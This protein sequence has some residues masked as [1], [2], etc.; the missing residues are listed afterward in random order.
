MPEFERGVRGVV[1]GP[2]PRLQARGPAA[3][4]EKWDTSTSYTSHFSHRATE[5]TLVV[6]PQ[7]RLVM[8]HSLRMS[9]STAVLFGILLLLS[10]ASGTE[11]VVE[12]TGLDLV[13]SWMPTL[14]RVVRFLAC[15]AG[16]RIGWFVADSWPLTPHTS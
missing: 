16:E 8:S 14:V 5:N 6:N 15:R 11:Q 2:R 12:P 13:W 7:E 1:A 4:K 9:S 10:T 3:L